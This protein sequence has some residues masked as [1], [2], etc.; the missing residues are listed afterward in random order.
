MPRC[1]QT[2]QHDPDFEMGVGI[3]EMG[4]GVLAADGES[5][6]L[7]LECLRIV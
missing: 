6:S 3:R 5:Q 4:G 2:I 1:L 7:L